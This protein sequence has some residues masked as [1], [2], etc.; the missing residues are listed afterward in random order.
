VTR[1]FTLIQLI[2]WIE[3]VQCKGEGGEMHTKVLSKYQVGIRALGGPDLKGD[4]IKID[5]TG[6][7]YWSF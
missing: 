4:N 6:A 1:V 5:M 7:E 2:M 3:R